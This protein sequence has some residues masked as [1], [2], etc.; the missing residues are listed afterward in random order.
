MVV[1]A[2]AGL[3][4]VVAAISLAD[5][6]SGTGVA[7]S[8]SDSVTS[9]ASVTTTAAVTTSAAATAATTTTTAAVAST[10]PAGSPGAISAEIDRVLAAV[11]PP[12]YK[13]KDVRELQQRI[14]RSIEQWENDSTE[15][16]AE[17]LRDALQSVERFPESATRDEL[18]ALVGALAQA[19][20]LEELDD[21]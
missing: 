19:M 14:D 16:S 18:V 15:R 7:I 21:D 9:P 3:L 8:P 13:P 10:L 17:I 4:I 11:G 1:A 12:D 5:R 6:L 20:D 2:A